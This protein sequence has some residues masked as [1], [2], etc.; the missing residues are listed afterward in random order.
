M[1]MNSLVFDFKVEV[2]LG[3]SQKKVSVQSTSSRLGIMGA[4]GCGKSSLIKALAGINAGFSGEFKFQ[5]KKINSL[6]PWER[7]F[8]FL[9]QTIQL[10]PHLNI[11]ENLL[12]P[13]YS[14]LNDE[15]IDALGIR[16]LL[17]RMPRN[18]SGGEKQR[19]GLAR[20]LCFDSKLLILDEPFSSLDAKTKN[21]CLVFL[22]KFTHLKNLPM[23]V[24]SHQADELMGLNC[25]IHSMDNG[26][27][28][29]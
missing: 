28:T 27:E 13:K 8:S 7:N 16:H 25:E 23:L 1:E 4:S 17:K 22:D 14:S 3:N 26:I 12:F 21:R 18:L 29:D 19:V 11:Q 9:P 6:N 20:A 2:N 10:L 5:N 24:V 15:V